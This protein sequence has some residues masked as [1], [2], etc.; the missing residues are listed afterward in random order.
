MR[1]G[2][3]DRSEGGPPDSLDGPDLA[4]LRDELLEAAVIEHPTERLLEIAAVIT[5]A[6]SDLPV[7]PV[8]VGGLALAY[9]SE[10][11]FE[12][13]DID[14]V[15]PRIAELDER[16]DAL[17]LVRRGREWM[18]PGHDVAFEAPAETLEPGDRAE[19]VELPSGRRVLV[20]SLEDML[21]WRLREW[22]YWR[23]ASGFQQAAHLLIAEP[24]DVER[25]DRRAAEEGLVLALAELR[26]LTAEI[27]SGR[28]YE[29]WEL[30]EIGRKIERTSYI[31]SD[32]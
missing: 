24:L 18:L 31:P 25:L 4:R 2:R 19:P 21:L 3:G 17:G 20:L 16:L 22:V 9:W 26:R 13:G 32:E 12:T 7:Q 28:A 23:I 10:S 5:E 30:A 11:E 6:F 14:V 27:E 29:D 8:V 15:M 1:S